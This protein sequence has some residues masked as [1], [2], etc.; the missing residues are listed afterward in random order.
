MP[1]HW[2]EDVHRALEIKAVSQLLWP[3]KDREEWFSLVENH[4][5]AV[6]FG[7][8]PLRNRSS[9]LPCDLCGVD[10]S[11]GLRFVCP[12]VF[13]FRLPPCLTFGAHCRRKWHFAVT[14]KVSL[15]SGRCENIQK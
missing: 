10:L 14:L 7:L 13:I 1:L 6:R 11:N 3:D 4:E 15:P 9:G 5:K 12:W 2:L 8:H